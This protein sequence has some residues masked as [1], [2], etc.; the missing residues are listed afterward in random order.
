[1]ADS[2]ILHRHHVIPRCDPRC[3]NGDGNLAILCPNCHSRVH[4]GEIVIIGVYPS[5]DGPTTIWFERGQEP[6]FPEEFWLVKDNP[7]VRTLGGD[8]D[9]LPTEEQH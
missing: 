4:A 3:V 6:P 9:D 8:K 1:M 5:T 7:L 2:A